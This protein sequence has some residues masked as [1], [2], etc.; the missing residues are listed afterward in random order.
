MTELSH[1]RAGSEL[2]VSGRVPERLRPGAP[3]CVL[4]VTPRRGFRVVAPWG[5]ESS[6]SHADETRLGSVWKCSLLVWG[7]LEGRC[8]SECDAGVLGE[9]QV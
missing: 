6:I 7:G 1:A 5:E 9:Q 4:Q 3:A 8:L 2:A